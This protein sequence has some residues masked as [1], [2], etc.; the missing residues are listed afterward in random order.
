[1]AAKLY[2]FGIFGSKIDF[3]RFFASMRAL[4]SRYQFENRLDFQE[5]HWLS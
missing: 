1:M 3:W 4:E 5:I 2:L